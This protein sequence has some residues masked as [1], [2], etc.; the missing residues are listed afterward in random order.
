MGNKEAL[1]KYLIED[2]L[3]NPQH[4]GKT[5][6][7]S[8]SWGA[9]KTYFWLNDIEPE[10]SKKLKED[11]RACIYISLYGKDSLKD[12][13]SSVYL[14]ASGKNILSEEVSTFGLETLSAIK[15]SELSVG[16][17][18]KAGK[19]LYDSRK[20]QK[21]L[22]RLKKG[23]IICFDD[24]ERKSSNIDLNDLFG[25]IS[26]LATNLQC[27]VIIILNSEVF[28]DK[29]AE[30]F[31]NVKEKTINKFLYFE[32]SI[33]ELFETIAKNENYNLLEEYKKDILEVLESTDILNA[34]IYTQVLDNC[35]EWINKKGK[36]N[37]DTKI[38]Q[39]LTLVTINF[40]INHLVFKSKLKIAE[41]N[42]EAY[43]NLKSFIQIESHYD[44]KYIENIIEKIQ[45]DTILKIN[46]D[47][48]INY[49]QNNKNFI[50]SLVILY[51]RKYNVYLYRVDNKTFSDINDFVKTGVL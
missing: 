39:A 7:L 35:L 37:T 12:I 21:G 48:Y 34:R 36:A 51:N 19:D 46:K 11:N 22:N 42:E 1:K 28:T 4:N 15:N 44:K 41:F 29:E 17:I 38:I 33:K 13:K 50:R 32:P 43:P 23:G 18:L 14:S 10:I 2:F 25:F 26:Q 8:G 3:P 9:G 47:V 20:I 49:I 31:R 30:V 5:V 45:N 6:M 27:K 40:V 16:K 24:F